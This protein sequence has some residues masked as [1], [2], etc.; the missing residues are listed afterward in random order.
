LAVDLVDADEDEDRGKMLKP[1]V[2]R[3]SLLENAVELVDL[4]KHFNLTGDPDM[5]QARKELAIAVMNHDA[6][7]L[8]EDML[9][10]EAVKNKVDAILGKFSF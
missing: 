1:R 3:D 6:T 8:R 2:F 4:L 7:Q 9:A 10:R 5:E